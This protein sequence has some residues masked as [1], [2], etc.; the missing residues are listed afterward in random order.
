MPIYV[1]QCPEC[2]AKFEKLTSMGSAAPDC[3]DCG[4]E[5]RKVPAPIQFLSVSGNGA[6]GG[7]AAYGAPAPRAGGMCGCGHGGCGIH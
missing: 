2:D 5:T 7:S 4:G 3:P 6:N 1:Y